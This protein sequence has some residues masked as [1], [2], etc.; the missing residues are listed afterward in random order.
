MVWVLVSR[1]TRK[2]FNDKF[3]LNM[4]I[5]FSSKSLTYLVFTAYFFRGVFEGFCVQSSGLLHGDKNL[6]RAYV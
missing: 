4:I 1:Y 2:L 5:S 6:Q 3:I